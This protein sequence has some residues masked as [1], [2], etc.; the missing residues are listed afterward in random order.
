MAT[1]IDIHKTSRPNARK[2]WTV[3]YMPGGKTNGKSFATKAETEAEVFRARDET[4]SR[5]GTF[6]DPRNGSTPVDLLADPKDLAVAVVTEPVETHC[7]CFRDAESATPHQPDREGEVSGYPACDGFNLS[8][9][10]RDDR[11]G[12]H[13]L[14]ATLI[15]PS[16]SFRRDCLGNDSRDQRASDVRGASALLGPQAGDGFPVPSYLGNGLGAQCRHE[17]RPQ[18]RPVPGLIVVGQVHC[19]NPVCRVFTEGGRHT[20]AAE[21]PASW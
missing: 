7:Q 4:G 11:R 1:I 10:R 12:L 18:R 9:G 13:G 21:G 3:R 6:V 14:S 5:D 16:R 8:L 19:L 20:R 15:P 17:V 2:P